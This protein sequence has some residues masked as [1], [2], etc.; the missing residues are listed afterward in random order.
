MSFLWICCLYIYH[1]LQL[2]YHAVNLI[3]LSF[4]S[5]LVIFLLK[6]LSA[7]HMKVIR[8]KPNSKIFYHGF[9]FYK[10]T[11]FHILY[12]FLII[13]INLV[14][15]SFTYNFINMNSIYH[16]VHLIFIFYFFYFFVTFLLKILATLYLKVILNN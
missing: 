6:M 7:L 12:P 3:F 5:L 9:K 1:W 14:H 13:F 2:I 10:K 8:N 11:P 4:F 16:V 15:L